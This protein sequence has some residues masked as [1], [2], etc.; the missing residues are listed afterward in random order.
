LASRGRSNLSPA[1]GSQAL[2]STSF[3]P[4]RLKALHADLSAVL[5][6]PVSAARARHGKRE[7]EGWLQR[8]LLGNFTQLNAHEPLLHGCDRCRRSF[9]SSVTYPHGFA[10]PNP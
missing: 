3:S 4:Q 9:A 1:L 7:R 5:Y 6:Q 10:N 8:C 2:W